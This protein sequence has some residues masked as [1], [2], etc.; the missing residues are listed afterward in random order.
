MTRTHAPSRAQTKL[1]PLKKISAQGFFRD[2][3]RTALCGLWM[4]T[5]VVGSNPSPAARAGPV[6]TRS[7]TAPPAP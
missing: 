1:E 7:S 3:V 4:L 5:L 6:A 2:P